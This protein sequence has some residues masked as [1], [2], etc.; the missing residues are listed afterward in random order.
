MKAELPLDML[1]RRIREALNDPATRV[2]PEDRLALEL[3]CRE[4]KDVRDWL[5]HV[6]ARAQA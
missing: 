6:K 3:T 4:W 2:A 1:L 5:V